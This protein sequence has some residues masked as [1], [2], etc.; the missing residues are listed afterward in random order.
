[1]IERKLPR[2]TVSYAE[3]FPHELLEGVRHHVEGNLDI[4]PSWLVLLH[5]TYDAD[6]PENITAQMQTRVDYRRAYLQI[7]G[8]WPGEEEKYRRQV[9]IHEFLHIQVAPLHLVLSKALD[10]IEPKSKEVH[11]LMNDDRQIAHEQTVVD[12]TELVERLLARGDEAD[13]ATATPY[14]VQPIDCG[15]GLPISPT[16]GG[17]HAV[18]DS[19]TQG[20]AP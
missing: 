14:Q 2:V 10:F 1:M 9:I 16:R 11:D 18:T 15:H 6:L 12:L 4:L 13:A 3:D 7:G 20:L 17:R 5:V 8:R 19:G